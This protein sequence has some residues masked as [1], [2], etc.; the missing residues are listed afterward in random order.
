MI[1]DKF[2]KND[3]KF[4]KKGDTVEVTLNMDDK[5]KYMVF[6][7]YQPADVDNIVDRICSELERNNF[8]AANLNINFKTKLLEK[9]ILNCLSDKLSKYDTETEVSYDNIDKE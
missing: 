6:K 3:R 7:V 5:K 9:Y 2:R 4:S 8:S 1:L